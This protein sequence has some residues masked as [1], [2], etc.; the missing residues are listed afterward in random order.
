MRAS[1]LVSL[2]LLLQTRQKM[3]ATA[4]AEELEVSLRTVY[5]DVEALGAAGVPVYAESGPG[6]GISL[7][8]GYRTRLTG[9]TPEEAGTLF[10]AG[11]PGPAAQLGLG[12]LL[13]AAQLKV[14]ASL[15]PELATHASRAAERFYLDVPGWYQSAEDLPCLA[16]LADAVWSGRRAVLS[17]RHRDRVVRRTVDP[18]GLVL[19]GGTWYLVAAKRGSPR[20]FRVSRIRTLTVTDERFDRLDD[21][22]LARYWATSTLDYQTRAGRVQVQVRLPAENLDALA[23][24]VEP[25][26]MHAALAASGH[27]TETGQLTLVVP[28]DSIREAHADLVR[29]GG[30]IEVLAPAELRQQLADTGRQLT[31]MYAQSTPSHTPATNALRERRRSGG[32]SLLEVSAYPAL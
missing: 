24:V 12:A 8:D 19:K 6:G 26:A 14:L 1:R 21:F 3:T 30:Q 27:A 16:P 18:L 22:D 23:Y 7:V 32:T 5:R 11:V 10:L 15:T 9:L 4:L 13:A 25:A 31:D 20:T 17:Y 2:L 29:L 28:F